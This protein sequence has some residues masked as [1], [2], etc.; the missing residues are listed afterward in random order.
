MTSFETNDEENPIATEATTTTSTT[1]MTIAKD[2]DGDDEQQKQTA[3][4][5]SNETSNENAKVSASDKHTQTIEKINNLTI[6][7]QKETRGRRFKEEHKLLDDCVKILVKM[8]DT[9]PICT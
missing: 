5:T 2:D 9:C 3:I 1:A 4:T 6:K 8:K 7:T